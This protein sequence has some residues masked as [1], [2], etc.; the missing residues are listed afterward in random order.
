MHTGTPT[1]TH[2]HTDARTH[3]TNWFWKWIEGDLDLLLVQVPD[4]HGP[5]TG[6]CREQ[7]GGHRVEQED[8]ALVLVACRPEP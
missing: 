4:Q 2:A 8:V 3:T 1:P 5:V 6:G 7:R